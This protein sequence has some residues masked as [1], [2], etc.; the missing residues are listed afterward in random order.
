MTQENET[1]DASRQVLRQGS[2]YT[3]AAAAPILVTILI[4]PVVTR[5]L[6]SDEYGIV[7]LSMTLIQIGLVVLNL[8]LGEP[9]TRHGVMEKSGIA[10]ARW[11][12]IAG[13]VPS[14]ILTLL[15]AASSVW[16]VPALLHLEWRPSWILAVVAAFLFNVITNIQAVLRAMDRPKYFVVMAMLATL[17]GPVIGLGLIMVM[18]RSADMYLWGLVIGYGISV[19]V[20]SPVIL[21]GG[22]MEHHKGD[23]T[24]SIRMGLPMVFNQIAVYLVTA[25]L[26]TMATR[27][28]GAGD[29]GRMQLALFVG[30]APSVIAVAFSNSWAPSIYRTAESQRAA[31]ASRVARDLGSVISVMSAGLAM[32]SPWVLM[33]LVPESYGPLRLAHVAAAAS[34]AGIFTVAY[35]ASVHL[36]MSTGRNLALAIIVPG[37]VAVMAAVLALGSDVIP[38]DEIGWGFPFAYLLMAVAAAVT[39]VA[40]GAP[41]WDP[42]PMLPW[43]VGSLVFSVLGVALP[44]TGLGLVIR[45]VASVGLAV[46][47]LRQLKNVLSS[48]S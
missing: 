10:G 17:G 25:T 28:G 22:P 46:L 29:G 34:P 33:F 38:A 19:L 6:G 35:L 27:T 18:G 31:V 12:N 42:R 21:R 3:A 40:I 32:L 11:L 30:S 45:L 26:I 44:A 9:I 37:S 24:R 23:F 41:R 43:I 39:V 48:A 1:S 47:G 16:W 8:G 20:G 4:T 2:L 5:L 13:L 15:I 36:I 14:S 7:G